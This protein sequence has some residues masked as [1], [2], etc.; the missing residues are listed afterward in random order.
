[1]EKAGSEPM[2]VSAEGKWLWHGAHIPE[3]TNDMDLQ[4]NFAVAAD[5]IAEALAFA[6]EHVI[7]AGYVLVFLSRGDNL[8]GFEVTLPEGVAETIRRHQKKVLN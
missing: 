6:Q 2:T 5:D 1:M 4:T 3:E 7:P 8:E